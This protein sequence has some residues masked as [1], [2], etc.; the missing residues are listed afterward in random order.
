M[1]TNLKIWTVVTIAAIFYSVGCTKTEIGNMDNNLEE[2][3]TY[4]VTLGMTGEIL[5]IIDEPLTRG[6]KTD[7]IYG[8]Q[9]YSTPNKSGEEAPVWTKFAYG[10][11]DSTDSISIN[12]LKGYRYKFVASMV[13]DGQNNIASTRIS[14][15]G[16]YSP[17][18]ISGADSRAGILNN[19]FD[20]QASESISDL[21]RGSTYLKSPHNIFSR[22]NLERFYGELVDYT[23]GQHGNKA[24]I[25]MKRTSFGAKFIAK[26]KLAREGYL[27]IHMNEAPKMYIDLTTSN[28]Q[29]S[30]IFTF[31]NVYGAYADNNYTEDVSVTLNWH[32]SDETIFPLGT[33]TI[34]FKRNRTSVV[35]VAIDN[36]NSES[37]LGIVIE[38][39]EMIEDD[40][41]TNIEDGEIVDTEVD[42]NA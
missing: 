36:E 37:D 13:V 38:D 42:T 5:E 10:L 15:I 22:P 33:H 25:K 29:V 28:K 7:D 35:Q 34:T 32:K 24:L 40:E 31:S 16:F 9:V 8:I 39:E 11:F 14:P 41:V 4:T 6:N 12:L 2:Q 20:Y 27:E 18:F 1:G 19:K 30:D 17:F 3:E 23:P 26:G 21:T